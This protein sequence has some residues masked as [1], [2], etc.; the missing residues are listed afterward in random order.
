M[1]ARGDGACY[2]CSVMIAVDEAGAV[3][4]VNFALM[5]SSYGAC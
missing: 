5:K 4:F 2:V 1:V 3:R